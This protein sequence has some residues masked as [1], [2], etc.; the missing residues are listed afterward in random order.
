MNLK[1]SQDIRWDVVGKLY[2][3]LQRLTPGTQEAEAID[4]AITLAL[5]PERQAQNVSFL[6]YDVLRNARYS[7]RRTQKRCGEL[8]K[9]LNVY[10]TQTAAHL[11]CKTPEAICIA[12][13]IEVKIRETLA[14]RDSHIMRCF[15][16][17]LLGE[18]ISETATA[19]GISRRSVDRARQKIR[20]ISRP[21]FFEEEVG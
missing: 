11:N 10:A 16:G 20:T 1:L 8:S 19:C 15:E 3:R 17:M 18:S 21:F 13:E 9:K 2:S 4:H 6:V 7:R 5:N 12:Q 14:Q